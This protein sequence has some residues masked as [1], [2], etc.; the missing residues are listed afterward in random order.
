MVAQSYLRPLTTLV[1][2]AGPGLPEGHDVP[3]S[4]VLR[5]QHR[6]P[7][8]RSITLRGGPLLYPPTTTPYHSQPHYLSP[9]KKIKSTNTRGLHPFTSPS[10]GQGYNEQTDV[11]DDG[12]V[13]VKIITADP[14]HSTCYYKTPR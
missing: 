12:K 8:L 6:L 2:V 10:H 1:R 5:P 13:V 7:R 9:R 11:F 3:M 14:P 4:E